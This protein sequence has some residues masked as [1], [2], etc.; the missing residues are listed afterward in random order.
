MVA[1]R[2]RHVRRDGPQWCRNARAIAHLW[3]AHDRAR[4][5]C[6]KEARKRGWEAI[7]RTSCARGTARNA[8]RYTAAVYAKTVPERLA[9]V[10]FLGDRYEA[11]KTDHAFA[12]PTPRSLRL[13]WRIAPGRTA[14]D[15]CAGAGLWPETLHLLGFS[16]V[17]GVDADPPRGSL[18]VAAGDG[19]TAVAAAGRDVL[20]L[21]WPPYADVECE[22]DCVA[23]RAL[24]RFRG[25]YV[26]HV[27]ELSGAA[28]HL[29]GGQAPPQTGS[30]A[31]REALA[32]RFRL[33]GRAPVQR[34]PFA[35]D[36]LTIWRRRRT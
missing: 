30:A 21:C 19:P 36:A 35:H 29:A 24:D 8:A 27:G 20:F 23:A 15:P 6:W 11:I 2:R 22:A 9:M 33:V 7:W 3:R 31:F 1:A 17:V 26:A 13:L 10:D 4:R 16:S 14:I 5:S 12:A 28:G 34:T 25:D 32:S 18:G